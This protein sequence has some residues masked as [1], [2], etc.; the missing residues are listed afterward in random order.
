[1]AFLR[2]SESPS[3]PPLAQ[4]P[5]YP[6][7]PRMAAFGVPQNTMGKELGQERTEVSSILTAVGTAASR[8]A[9]PPTR[10]DLRPGPTVLHSVRSTA[11]SEQ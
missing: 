9:L 1:V 5:T 4:D 7:L 11:L 8:C 6:V 2:A 3:P 10:P